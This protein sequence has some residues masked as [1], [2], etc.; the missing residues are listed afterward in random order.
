MGNKTIDLT[1]GKYPSF[2]PAMV[3]EKLTIKCAGFKA[4]VSGK[5]QSNSTDDGTNIKHGGQWINFTITTYPFKTWGDVNDIQQDGDLLTKPEI[6]KGPK[7][8]LII[9]VDIDFEDFWR[10]YSLSDPSPGTPVSIESYADY[11][12]VISTV[13]ITA[14]ETTVVFVKD[15]SN[16]YR[17]GETLY[18]HDITGTASV[19]NG[20]SAVITGIS[21][22]TVTFANTN[23]TTLNG[24]GGYTLGRIALKS[25]G[26][27]LADGDVV[28]I[29]GNTWQDYP[30]WDYNGVYTIE[31]LDSNYFTI[32]WLTYNNL[33]DMDPVGNKGTYVLQNPSAELSFPIQVVMNDWDSSSD[34]PN[35]SDNLTMTLTTKKKITLS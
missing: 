10:F 19:L 30:T 33:E 17:V 3:T 23:P 1:A 24:T 9:N 16:L 31:V 14:T 29:Y 25:T 2:S 5:S 20:T 32:E 6:F 13:T 34:Y 7:Y 28:Y 26:H 4:T 18:F 35:G 22:F 15:A 27:G 11:S 12:R 21:S 8:L